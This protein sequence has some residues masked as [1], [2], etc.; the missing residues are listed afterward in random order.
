MGPTSANRS[1][2]RFVFA[3]S[4]EAKERLRPGLSSGN[5]AKT[6]SASVTVIVAYDQ[7]FYEKMPELFPHE[8]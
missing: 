8:E 7:D 3:R 2:G 1:P 5:T 6:M 4:A